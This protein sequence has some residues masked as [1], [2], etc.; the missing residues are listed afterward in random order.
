MEVRNF[1][2]PS[3]INRTNRI[4]FVNRLGVKTQGRRRKL[5][6]HEDNSL[7]HKARLNDPLQGF[8]DRCTSPPDNAGV[9][10]GVMLETVQESSALDEE[11]D[12]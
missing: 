4:N 9:V 12:E 7:L 1:P 10:E 8:L 11:E 6:A 2:Q 5:S 3:Q